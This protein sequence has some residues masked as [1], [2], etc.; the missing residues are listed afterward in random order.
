MRRYL[1]LAIFGWRVLS[2][3]LA[4][5]LPVLISCVYD[6]IIWVLLLY[7]SVQS[8]E[9]ISSLEGIFLIALACLF[10]GKYVSGLSDVMQF[11]YEI[12]IGL[13]VSWYEVDLT[14]NN[15]HKPGWEKFKFQKR[16]LPPIPIEVIVDMQYQCY[17]IM[18]IHVNNIQQMECHS[19]FFP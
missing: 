9:D 2:L 10:F 7:F 3:T 12:H 15:Y 19:Y 13:L 16:S 11:L 14:N 8:L 4:P 17:H 18:I 6:R 1:R 5:N